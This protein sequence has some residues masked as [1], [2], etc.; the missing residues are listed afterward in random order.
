MP[1]LKKLGINRIG[2]VK[3]A[4]SRCDMLVFNDFQYSY[5]KRYGRPNKRKR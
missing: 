2:V 1:F 5:A 4:E 3:P